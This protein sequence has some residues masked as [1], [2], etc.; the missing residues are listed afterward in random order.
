MSKQV[1]ILVKAYT[2]EEACERL[3]ILAE[4]RK[5]SYTRGGFYSIVR[6]YKPEL[7]E[8]VITEEDLQF[9]ADKMR[10][11]GRPKNIDKSN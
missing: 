11:P 6:R 9:I 8:P 2:L 5:K 3:A 7:I 1:S 4:H 10:K